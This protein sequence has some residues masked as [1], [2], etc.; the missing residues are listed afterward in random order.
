MTPGGVQR[1]DWEPR[2]DPPVPKSYIPTFIEDSI[3]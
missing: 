2:F 1:G 3:L